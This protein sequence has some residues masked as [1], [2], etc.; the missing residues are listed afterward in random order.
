MD[1]FQ[2]YAGLSIVKVRETFTSIVAY[3]YPYHD[4]FMPESSGCY[5][6]RTSPGRTDRE[7][8]VVLDVAR[9]VALRLL[10]RAHIDYWRTS[11]EHK[12]DDLRLS[13]AYWTVVD[14]TDMLVHWLTD[15][16]VEVT[17]SAGGIRWHYDDNDYHSSGAKS[18]EFELC[19]DGW[20]RRRF[21]VLDEQGSYAGVEHTY[22]WME[23]VRVM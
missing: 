16:H 3:A 13:Q 14:K 11:K 23:E 5:V 1:P 18:T 20:R 6:Y 4:L 15:P 21:R 10:E 7:D 9:E 17:F 22:R 2:I 8:A 19:K 12:R